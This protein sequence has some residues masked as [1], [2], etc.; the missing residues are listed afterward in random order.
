MRTFTEFL[1][2]LVIEELHPELK[3]V[4]TA[5][6][7]PTTVK[8][9]RV[10]QKVKE[11][12]TRGERTGIE[13]KM[14]EG[15]SR[16]YLPHTDDHHTTV[17]GKPASFKTGT[18]VA[19]RASLDKHHDHDKY[20]GSLGEMQNKI[21]N[22]DYRINDHYRILTKHSGD[23]FHGEGYSS[24][25]EHGIFPPLVDHDHKKGQWS[26][27][28]AARNIKAGEFQKLTKT[29]SHPKGISHKEFTDTLIRNYTRSH[30]RYWEGPV[31]HEKNLNHVERHP[32]VQKFLD[33]Q[34]NFVGMPH[35]YQQLKNMGVFEHPDGSKHIVARDHGFNSS[36][37]EAYQAARQKSRGRVRH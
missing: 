17:D 12:S 7:S 3:A 31:E 37:A 20:D 26:T 34:H 18:K 28:G 30:G 1:D 19:I 16:A 35:D 32:L 24:N 11:L 15:S 36:V 29:A 33:H 22:G 10:I 4:I 25:K 8:H 23:L 6:D 21:E 27:V 14:P 9:M 2:S 13:D 5:E